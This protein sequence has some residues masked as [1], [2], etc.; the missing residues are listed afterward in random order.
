MVEIESGDLSPLIADFVDRL[1]QDNA[2]KIVE[3]Y[4]NQLLYVPMRG[5]SK[6]MVDRLGQDLADRLV[7]EYRG[8]QWRV[9]C[10]SS[11]ERHKRNALM[12]L[13]RSEGKRQSEIALEFNLTYGQVGCILRQ[14][15]AS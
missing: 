6:E 1:G 5:A 3:E 8:C 13:R 9:P 7:E 11:I 15:N 10:A 12:R 2:L 4:R 14:S